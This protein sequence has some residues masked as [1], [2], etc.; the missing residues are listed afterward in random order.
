MPEEGVLVAQ[1]SDGM[2]LVYCFTHGTI[3]EIRF[4][5]DDGEAGA[6]ASADILN[7]EAVAKFIELTHDR[8]YEELKEYFGNTIIAFFTDEPCALGRNAGRFRQWLPNLEQEI[9]D[10]GGS[11]DEL[12]VPFN[13]EENDTVR[14]TDQK[15][16][17]RE[18]LSAIVNMVSTT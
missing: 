6:P 11:L 9:I 8:Y 7:P 4:G 5:E 1:F 13:K 15:T 17:A 2:K 14:I 16:F 12:E 10:A 3:R 18:F